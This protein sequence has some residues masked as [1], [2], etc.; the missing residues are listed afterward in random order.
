[1]TVEKVLNTTARTESSLM[2]FRSLFRLILDD[3]GLKPSAV[4][5]ALQRERTLMYKWLSG[6]SAPPASYFP[7]IVDIV[8]THTSE[9]RKVILQQDLRARVRVAGLTRDVRKTL[10]DTKTLESLLSECLELS[11]LS[12]KEAEDERITSSESRW[13]LWII[14]GAVFAAITGGLLWNMLNRILGWPYYMDG[15]DD[16]LRGFHALVWGLVTTAPIPFALLFPYGRGMRR[17]LLM[18]ALLV[19]L[20]GALSALVFYSSGLRATVEGLQIS[21][22]IQETIIVIGFAA[23]LSLPALVAA[24]LAAPHRDPSTGRE[25]TRVVAALLLPTAAAVVALLVT[26]M[27]E[28]PVVEILQLRGLVVGFAFRLALFFS[29]F[30]VTGSRS[31]GVPIRSSADSRHATTFFV[32]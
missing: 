14:L 20:S 1:M 19:T 6:S 13:S 18:P 27:I 3:T 11:L 9:A 12:G 2:S 4:A 22:A 32:P 21:Y 24:I 17:G 23:C 10:L 28:R 31:P 5:L 16:S 8:S 30:L 7:L 25:P 15:A 29:L 26:L